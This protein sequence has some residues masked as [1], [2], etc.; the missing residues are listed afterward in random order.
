LRYRHFETLRPLCP[1][2]L[3][4]QKENHALE[5]AFIAKES[6]GILWEGILTCTNPACRHEYPVLDGIPI[7]LAD[8]RTYITNNLLSLVSRS[9]FTPQL[10]SLLG[11]CTG[12][13]STYDT[14]RQY[15]S[16]YAHGHYESDA[17]LHILNPLLAAL[18]PTSPALDIGCSVG[19]GTFALAEK[20]DTLTLGV[21]L[22]F[23]ML[24]LAQHALHQEAITYARRK[25]GLVYESRTVPITFPHRDHVDFWACD[26]LALPF[27]TGSFGT[28]TALNVLDCVAS[29]LL[30]LQEMTRLTRP[31]GSFALTTPFDWSPTA[32]PI[33][34]WIGGH[35]QRS[36]D[37]GAGEPFLRRLL[38]PG[39]HGQSLDDVRIRAEF[40]ELEWSVR[41]HER[42]TVQYQVYGLVTDRLV[43]FSE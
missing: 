18:T 1:V 17:L 31:G 35:S 26:A 40:P 28:I 8:P 5:I 12:P 27:A 39:Q 29:P 42:S 24:R 33:E 14:T 36:D 30:A 43:P 19:R 4:G 22:N 32:T 9:P 16:H 3:H 41:L 21:D 20:C 38:T 34:G 13:G 6:P 37:A 7:I 11:D 10:E 2:C 25:I 15:L 23:A